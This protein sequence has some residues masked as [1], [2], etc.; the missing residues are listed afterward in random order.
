MLLRFL[1]LSLFA[2]VVDSSGLTLLKKMNLI[3]NIEIPVEESFSGSS[4]MI[5]CLAWVCIVCVMIWSIWL[6]SKITIDFWD[7]TSLFKISS[8]EQVGEMIQGC[9]DRFEPRK[10]DRRWSSVSATRK[11]S[12]NAI[13]AV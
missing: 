12:M 6:E 4:K 3:P 13:D 10:I 7:P 8:S 2:S 11:A 9:A 1:S 5:L